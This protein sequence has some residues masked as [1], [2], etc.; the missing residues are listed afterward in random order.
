VSGGITEEDIPV[1]NPVVHGY[2]IGTSI[3]NAPVMDFAMD[4]VEIEGKPLAKRGKWSGSKSVLVCSLC[5]ERK[6]TPKNGGDERSC[7]CGGAFNDILVPMLDNGKLLVKQETPSRIRD[8]VLQ[9]VQ[10]LVL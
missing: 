5:G 3:S 6:I 4:I 8:S 10:G 2:G 9:Q 7:S 1:L